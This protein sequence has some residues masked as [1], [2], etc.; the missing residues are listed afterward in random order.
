LSII[1]QPF[2]ITKCQTLISRFATFASQYAGGCGLWAGG[3]G[4]GEGTRVLALVPWADM[5]NHCGA[6]G[7]AACLALRGGGGG[8]RSAQLRAHRPY[9]AKQQARRVNTR[10]R[11]VN[12][13]LSQVNTHLSKG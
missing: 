3:G 7:A 9:E 8:T 11:R 12:T 13:H 1:Q 4:E 10:L 5:L 6:A 2:S